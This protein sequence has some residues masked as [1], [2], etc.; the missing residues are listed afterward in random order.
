MPDP[1]VERVIALFDA[2]LELPRSERVAFLQR[3]C[4]ADSELLR[5]V[6]SLLD[7][8]ESQDSSFDDL[9]KAVVSPALGVVLGALDRSHGHAVRAELESALADRYRILKELGGGMSHVFVAIETRLARRVV[10]K[11]LPPE[12]GG[13]ESAERFRREI[14]LAA[15]LQHPHIVPLLASDA[16]GSLLYYTMPFISGET[17]RDRLTRT[18]RVTV[19]DAIALWRDVLEALG[20]AHANGVI[21]GDVKPENILLSGENALVSDFGVARALL[22]SDEEAATAEAR[23]MGTPTYMAPE[24]LLSAHVDHRA[25]L[26]AAGLVMQEMLEGRLPLAGDAPRDAIMA[27]LTSDSPPVRCADCPDALVRLVSQ[28]LARA[29][30]DRPASATAVLAELDRIERHVDASAATAR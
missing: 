17:L 19:P 23:V 18:G 2:A 3:E 1:R 10:I 26:F 9:A 5:E 16:A 27:R 21:H 30:A 13:R 22:P 29:P 20:H 15:Q 4:A 6:Q 28:C 25:D 24:Q 14:A 12:R 7:T 8:H 11:V